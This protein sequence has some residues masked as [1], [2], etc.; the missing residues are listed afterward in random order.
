M[1][2]TGTK[3]IQLLVCENAFGVRV[4]FSWINWH[5]PLNMP[6]DHCAAPS[7]NRSGPW[8]E[9]NTKPKHENTDGM[10]DDI[11]CQPS[12]RMHAGIVATAAA[13]ALASSA[14]STAANTSYG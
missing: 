5:L 7:V 4:S 1:F 13:A 10:S 11:S 8:S 6:R 3:L 2:A 12:Y 14:N 9:K